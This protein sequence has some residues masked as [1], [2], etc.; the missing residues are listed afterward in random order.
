ML[1]AGVAPAQV[2]DTVL[3]FPGR[4]V[5][6]LV[7]LPDQDRVY[8][9]VPTYNYAPSTHSRDLFAFVLD[10]ASHE[11]IGQLRLPGILGRTG[12][13]QDLLNPKM[14]R[15]YSGDWGVA[16]DEILTAVVD[17]RTDTFLR[18][19]DTKHYF[20]I[21][22][23][24]RLRNRVYG[25]AG[26]LGVFDCETESIVRVIA[27]EHELASFSVWDSVGDKVYVG[28]APFFTR[29][30]LLT[31]VDCRTDSIVAV[32]R[33]GTD[34]PEREWVVCATELRKLY[35]ASP[36][37]PSFNLAVVDCDADTLIRS[38]RVGRAVGGPMVYNHAENK[39]YFTTYNQRLPPYD[40]LAL[41]V[42]DCRTD[43]IVRL[44]RSPGLNGRGLFISQALADWSN[45]LYFVVGDGHDILL[46]ALDCRTDSIVGQAR[47]PRRNVGFVYANPRNRMLYVAASWDSVSGYQQELQIFR[48]ELQAVS[49]E[50]P[51][52]TRPSAPLRV[53]PNPARNLLR[54]SGT[55]DVGLYASDGRR[56]AVLQPGENDVRHLARGVYFVR[57]WDTGESARLVLVR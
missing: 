32:L 26:T 16:G 17:Y 29:P 21:A 19:V 25:V 48:D 14:E 56:V 15:F 9:P 2:L 6:A 11:V 42:V 28:T 49:E 38:L 3:R 8:V 12:P 22:A 24:N 4:R 53:A 27:A 51:A 44:V 55:E 46:S 33:T 47:I 36:Y 7:L 57:R 41:V 37:P 30:D 13:S 50:Q 54:L 35:I 43:S 18:W 45:R 31:A 10:E 39:L 23:L 52:A 1:V 5:G 40:T 20:Q 34:S